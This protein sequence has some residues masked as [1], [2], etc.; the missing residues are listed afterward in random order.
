MKL[1][2]IFFVTLLAT[3]NFSYSQSTCGEAIY[4]LQNYAVQVNRIYSDEYWSII[5][6]LRCPLTDSYGRVVNPM[7]VQNCRLQF[8]QHLNQWYFNQCT[9]VNNM[10][11]QIARSCSDST[12]IKNKP[13]PIS[14]KASDQMEEINTND[15]EELTAG[16]DEEKA[17]RITIPKTAAGFNPR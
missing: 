2:K 9:Y 3:Y 4:N 6:N 14:R 7:I 1:I 16:V 10:Y 12:P 5:P 13:A 11:A 15:I 17:V 8:L